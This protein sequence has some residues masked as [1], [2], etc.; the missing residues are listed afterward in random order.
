[1][2]RTL[3]FASVFGAAAMSGTFNPTFIEAQPLTVTGRVADPNLQPLPG[4]LVQGDSATR[5]LADSEGMYRIIVP[6]AADTLVFS[7]LGYKEQ[8]VPVQGRPSVDVTLEARPLELTELVAVGYSQQNRPTFSQAHPSPER[9][10]RGVLPCYG[11]ALP[12]PP[13]LEPTEPSRRM[14]PSDPPP[15]PIPNACAVST[16][17]VSDFP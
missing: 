3:W 4:V 15:V 9:I 13:A 2:I 16:A 10:P 7:V 12:A 5:T 6:H 17:D 11:A 1:M 8:R 14:K